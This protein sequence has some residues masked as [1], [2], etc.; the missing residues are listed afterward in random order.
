MLRHLVNPSQDRNPPTNCPEA[1]HAAEPFSDTFAYKCLPY[2]RSPS[3]QPP[4]TQLYHAQSI[5]AESRETPIE[6]PPGSLW[7]SSQS[8]D[9]S[10]GI[11][12]S[13]G[14]GVNPFTSQLWYNT[15]DLAPTLETIAG[16][17]FE[18]VGEYI[19]AGPNPPYHVSD[20]ELYLDFPTDPLSCPHPTASGIPSATTPTLPGSR[21]TRPVE[22]P[23]ET[24]RLSNT[25]LAVW[26]A[27]Q[28][29]YFPSSPPKASAVRERRRTSNRK[30]PVVSD[31]N[32]SDSRHACEICPRKFKRLE[33]LCRHNR[34]HTGERNFACE[35]EGCGKRFS[36]SDNLMAH[37][38]HPATPAYQASLISCRT[39]ANPCGR[40]IFVP[41][42]EDVG[43]GKGKMFVRHS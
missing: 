43:F 15:Q 1:F 2:T 14:G 41:S 12:A 25:E 4:E 38:R 27:D 7:P 32:S 30:L 42:T 31:S 35:I 24:H 22:G 29:P 18:E 40:N 9:S 33:H 26:V 21:A 17:N 8:S 19:R 37:R 39:H 16:F 3:I 6:S 5:A 23:P 10:L 36:R 20:S 34:I 13:P 28:S 11:L